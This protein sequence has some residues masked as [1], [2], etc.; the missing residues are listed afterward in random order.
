MHLEN[1]FTAMKLRTSM[2]GNLPKV[3]TCRCISCFGGVDI[4]LKTRDKVSL[5]KVL[6]GEK[7]A[8]C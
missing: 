7:M 5:F 8:F 1:L 6:L 3:K 2:I 4:L